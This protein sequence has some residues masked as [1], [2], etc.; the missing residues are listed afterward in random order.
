M[1]AWVTRAAFTTACAGLV[2]CGA[3]AP[4]ASA[5]GGASTPIP[6]CTNLS[7]Y[8]TCAVR[9]VPGPFVPRPAHVL[10]VVERSERL[11]R[12]LPNATNDLWTEMTRGLSGALGRPWTTV[13]FAMFGYPSG[14]ST[15]CGPGCC[16]M[17]PAALAVRGPFEPGNTPRII[18]VLLSDHP[19]GEA[20]MAAAL[21]TARQ[22]L[23]EVDV[24]AEGDA[25]VVLLAG[26]AA[27]C[28]ATTACDAQSCV[29]NVESRCASGGNCCADAPSFCLDNQAVTAQLQALTDAGIK[30]VVVALPA[31]A[32]TASTLNE[33]ARQGG[34][35]NPATG[36]AYSAGA[37]ATEIEATI[38]T[39]LESLGAR[40][41]A[42]LATAP[43]QPAA[44]Q[45][46][47]GCQV[48]ETA[49]VRTDAAGARIV[50]DPDACGALASTPPPPVNVLTDCGMPR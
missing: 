16:Y 36:G 42:A 1:S 4:N 32:T 47:A 13:D 27:D 8:A 2:A 38:A 11:L 30:T 26:G 17:L 44:A 19:E 23:T 34:R 49:E 25:F 29:P 22:Y 43:S 39:I 31:D 5:D 35:P 21:A 15:G 7:A 28:G 33:F 18:E 14:M 37:T 9:P 45:V 50:L 40:C 20:P 41:E 12:V 24:P 10:L 48:L 3:A 46:V 6:G